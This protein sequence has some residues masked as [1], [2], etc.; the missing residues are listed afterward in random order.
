MMLVNK[1]YQYSNVKVF[2][3]VVVVNPKPTSP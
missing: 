1:D 2:V 3:V